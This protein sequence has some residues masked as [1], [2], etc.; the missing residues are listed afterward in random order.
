MDARKLCE[1]LQKSVEALSDSLDQPVPVLLVEDDDLDAAR[2]S[3]VEIWTK[4]AGGQENLGPFDDEET[5]AFYCDVPDFL[6]TIPPA[7]LGITEEEIERRNQANAEKYGADGPTETQEGGEEAVDMPSED[8][9]DAVESGE[10]AE[11]EEEEAKT[12][13]AGK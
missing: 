13:D 4:E 5:R 12:N 9:L 10:M 7:L 2:G 6:T 1:S 8:Q 11:E 3:G